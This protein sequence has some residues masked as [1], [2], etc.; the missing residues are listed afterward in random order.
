[1][2]ITQ[3]KNNSGVGRYTDVNRKIFQN[4]VFYF[5]FLFR[6]GKEVQI[7]SQGMLLI[8]IRRKKK[9]QHKLQKIGEVLMKLPTCPLLS[10]FLTAVKM[11]LIFLIVLN[12]CFCPYI[13]THFITLLWNKRWRHPV[14]LALYV[15]QL[16]K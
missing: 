7:T 16:L 6:T 5:Y 4:S 2:E 8:R 1:M 11:S 13:F 9:K 3:V 10:H 14:S 12:W 15:V